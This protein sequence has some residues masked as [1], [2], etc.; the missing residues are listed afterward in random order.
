[1][2][3]NI[4][5]KNF[6]DT[7]MTESMRLR[8]DHCERIF[9]LDQTENIKP[10]KLMKIQFWSTHYSQERPLHY[11]KFWINDAQMATLFV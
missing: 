3:V 8:M 4:S 10:S 6:N 9:R 2:D 11:T 1:M 5:Q 7:H